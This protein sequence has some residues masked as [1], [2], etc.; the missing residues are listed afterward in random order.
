[1]I[2]AYISGRLGNQLFQYAFCKALKTVRGNTDQFVFNFSLVE[3]SGSRENGFEDSLKYLNVENYCTDNRNLT[4]SVGGGKIRILYLL[5]QLD[6]RYF[7]M[8]TKQWWYSVFRRNGLLF[9]D[10]SDNS[11]S[12]YSDYLTGSKHGADTLVCYGKYE[13]PQYFNGIRNELLKDFSPKLPPLNENAE[14]YNVIEN[15]N[16]VCV[17]IRRGDFLDKR[18]KNEFYICDEE[19]F[20]KAFKVVKEKV[21]APVLIFFSDDIEW[22]REN[23]KTELP[24]YYESGTDPV[25]EKLRLMYSCKHFVISNSTFSWWAQYLSRNEQKVVISPER[26]FVDEEKN[27]QCKLIQDN[28]IKIERIYMGRD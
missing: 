8:R 26:W 13:N 24:S 18:F 21:E 2:A 6:N 5:F 1:M 27:R 20:T 14:L 3:S 4:L 28:F 22:V 17:S 7:H 19:Y 15:S 12:N 11:F 16:S 10:Y 23:I 9:S 25:W